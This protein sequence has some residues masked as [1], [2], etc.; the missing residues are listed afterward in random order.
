MD[1]NGFAVFLFSLTL[2]SQG[3]Q[4]RMLGCWKGTDFSREG[5]T[6]LESPF[7]LGSHMRIELLKKMALGGFQDK[8]SLSQAADT[9]FWHTRGG[10]SPKRQ[11]FVWIKGPGIN[12]APSLHL[13]SLFQVRVSS[14][15]RHFF[16]ARIRSAASFSLFSFRSLLK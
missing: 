14:N 6:V 8:K 2:A 4:S 12:C 10:R 1:R 13:P 15:L 11:I 5:E 3:C 9:L 7:F 16:H